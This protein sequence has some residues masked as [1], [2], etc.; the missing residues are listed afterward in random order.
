[1][2]IPQRP[3]TMALAP[4]SQALPAVGN[5]RALT[6]PELF[7]LPAVIDLATAARA[8]GI[9]VNTAYKL[10]KRGE[11]PC[12]VLRPGYRYRV[13]TI[14]LM[15]ALEIEQIPVYLDDADRGA[16]FAGRFG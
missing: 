4:E 7:G 10:V 8:V 2:S 3:P 13:P 5:S 15:K 1:M 9:H 11:F 16:A 6:F 14:G 12:T